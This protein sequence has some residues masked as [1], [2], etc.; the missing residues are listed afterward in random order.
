VK[1][2]SGLWTDLRFAAL[3]G[4]SAVAAV[5]AL[6]PCVG[7]W[8]ARALFALA[9][10]PVAGVRCADSLGARAR[11]AA[12]LSLASLA[13][14]FAHLPWPALALPLAGAFGVARASCAA[15]GSPARELAVGAALVAGGLALGAFCDGRS[16]PS[17]G[18]AIW[19]FLLVQSAYALFESR[20]SARSPE[21][22]DPFERARDQALALLEGEPR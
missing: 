6:A 13:L 1:R 18:L 20:P 8:R 14:G 12:G 17:F 7:G 22:G 5:V 11:V 9:L 3:A 4:L 21:T 15:R 16:A 10:L 19:A 2:A